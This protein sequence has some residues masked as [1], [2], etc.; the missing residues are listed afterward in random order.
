M[1]F[2]LIIDGNELAKI[3]VPNIW[4]QALLEGVHQLACS[5]TVGSIGLLP[6]VKHY[7]QALLDCLVAT[8]K[9][10]FGSFTYALTDLHSHSQQPSHRFDD[11]LYHSHPKLFHDVYG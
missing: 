4:G 9:L 3:K 7:R 6:L 2:E 5:A 10:K 11:Y 1:R 8:D